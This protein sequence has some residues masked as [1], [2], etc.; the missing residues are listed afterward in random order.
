MAMIEA[1]ENIPSPTRG[2]V[3]CVIRS[4]NHRPESG[5]SRCHV[6]FSAVRHRQ[7]SG[8]SIYHVCT[9]AGKREMS[10]RSYRDGKFNIS[11][12][13]YGKRKRRPSAIEVQEVIFFSLQ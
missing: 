11:R 12:A 4:A 2:Y 3:T 5:S 13:H 7:Q 1:F 9:S 10:R 6:H 8:G